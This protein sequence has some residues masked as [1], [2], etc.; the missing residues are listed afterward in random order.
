M[1]IFTS[2]SAVLKDP[3]GV[4]KLS[5]GEYSGNVSLTCEGSSQMRAEHVLVGAGDGVSCK[6]AWVGQAFR[7][8]AGLHS[9][10]LP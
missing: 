6:A 4:S 10:A 5:G 7:R 9:H 3:L 8:A 2:P 1:S